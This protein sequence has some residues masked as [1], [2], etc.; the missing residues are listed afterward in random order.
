MNPFP[1]PNASN[2]A[3]QMSEDL[4][5]FENIQLVSQIAYLTDE[6]REGI[7]DLAEGMIV[8]DSPMVETSE[9]VAFYENV[10]TN[11][12]PIPALKGYLTLSLSD[13]LT[14]LVHS[15]NQVGDDSVAMREYLVSNSLVGKVADGI[16]LEGNSFLPGVKAGVFL[17]QDSKA[18]LQ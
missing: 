9:A 14:N 8:V 17:I 7:S 18:V 15:A 12:G 11:Y 1:G 5:K 16:D 6:S 13:A 10:E 2:L 3:K 4:S